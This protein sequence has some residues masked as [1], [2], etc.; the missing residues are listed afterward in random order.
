M[1]LFNST[2]ITYVVCT[3]LVYFILYNWL[4]VVLLMVRSLLSWILTLIVELH[5]EFANILTIN[6]CYCHDDDF[7]NL[8][9]NVTMTLRRLRGLGEHGKGGKV[10][11]WVI[12]YICLLLNHE[13][14]L[15]LKSLVQCAHY[16]SMY[17]YNNFLVWNC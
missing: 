4:G 15:V 3:K 10:T 7:K 16:Q 12:R 13:K 11:W 1:K 5:K 2:L 8:K 14:Q 9:N 6:Y 17:S